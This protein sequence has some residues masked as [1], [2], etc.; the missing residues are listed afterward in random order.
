MVYFIVNVFRWEGKVSEVLSNGLY[1]RICNCCPRT[2]LRDIIGS[3]W[4][5]NYRKVKQKYEWEVNKA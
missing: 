5:E 1:D 4:N 3:V 2:I